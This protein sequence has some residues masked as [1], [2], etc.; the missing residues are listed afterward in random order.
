[1]SLLDAARAA[2]T[3]GLCV[4]PAARD[5]TKAPWPDAPRWAKYQRE[6]PEADDLERWFGPEAYP[7]MGLVCGAVSGGL[8]MLEFE[9][10]AVGEGLYDEFIETARAVGVWPVARAP[11]DILRDRRDWNR[12]VPTLNVLACDLSA[13]ECRSRYSLWRPT[14][15]PIG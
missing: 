7:G 10:R 4:I 13:T 2:Q 9:G 3:A 1:M 6:L 15:F 5:G 11:G 12:Q 8:E 14:S